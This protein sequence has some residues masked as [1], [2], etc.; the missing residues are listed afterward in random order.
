MLPVIYYLYSPSNAEISPPPLHHT[1]MFAV[2]CTL[3]TPCNVGSIVQG[4]ENRSRDHSD[5]VSSDGIRPVIHF[6][7]YLYSDLDREKNN[8]RTITSSYPGIIYMQRTTLKF[9][10]GDMFVHYS[11]SK[12]RILWPGLITE[13]ARETKTRH[14][15]G[16]N[17]YV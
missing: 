15:L 11:V 3:W 4:S 5:R 9:L 12:N 2:F 10:L 8:T 14:R 16:F 13:R 17:Q 7:S 1:L 6:I